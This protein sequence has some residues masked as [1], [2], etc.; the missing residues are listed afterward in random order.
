MMLKNIRVDGLFDRFTHE[1]PLNLAD[2]ITIIHGPNG[3]GKTMILRMLDAFFNYSH[4]S[5]AKIPFRELR[6][7]FDDTTVVSVHRTLHELA[8]EQ[9]E[10]RAT[11][12]FTYSEPGKPSQ[13]FTPK[14]L[15]PVEQVGFPVGMIEEIIPELDQVD[16]LEWR[17]RGTGA[18]LSLEE[19]LD[20]YR[21]ELPVDMRYRDLKA[22]TWLRGIR[23]AV[24]VRFINTE[25]LYT[26]PTRRRRLSLSPTYVSPEPAVRRYSEELGET[27]RLTLTEYG[28]LS[29]SL[30]R[31]FPGR[32]VAEPP[33]S[34][35]TKEE[36]RKELADIET[37]RK[38]LLEAGLLSQESGSRLEVTSMPNLENI[39]ET[40]RGVLSVYAR[41]AKQKLG[42][43]DQVFAKID[44][45]KKLVNARF[46][47][48]KIT[49]EQS[50][51]QVITANGTQLDPVLLSSGEQHEIVL[52]YELLFRVSE[53]SILLIDEP[54]LSL[55]IAW[56][57]AF[58][59]DL[60]KI[61]ALSR[62]QALIATHSPQIIN[63]RWDLTVEL[64]GPV[65]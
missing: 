54:E 3:F 37:K 62:I 16:R 58:L 52:L 25:R 8:G 13:S 51:F 49:V 61:T 14:P 44:L 11:V 56:Q 21:D 24:P 55:H 39:D 18:I 35:V 59:E 45:F 27:I 22:P 60:G 53:N 5:L 57:E 46:L 31:T 7:D 2:R 33:L 6:L 36:L 43:F 63:D 23:E 10:E 1:I 40:K 32:L 42:V 29:Q 38:Q 65:T 9:S 30:D 12:E 17:H 15:S 48:K 26:T 4:L 41:D 28:R 19:V 47:H 64:K 34:G 20:K 50:G